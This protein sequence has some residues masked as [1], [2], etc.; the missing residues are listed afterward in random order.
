MTN[1]LVALFEG[2]ESGVILRKDAKGKKN[3]N[4]LDIRRMVKRGFIEGY[5]VNYNNN[6]ISFLN[7][8]YCTNDTITFDVF[9]NFI[10]GDDGMN[11][12]DMDV[13][14]VKMG[15]DNMFG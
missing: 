5:D 6:Y 9:F 10:E 3:W 13:P 7:C 1:E 4:I 15:N 12:E 14:V 8:C 2:M 11:I